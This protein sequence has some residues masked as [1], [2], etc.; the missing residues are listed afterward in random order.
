MNLYIKQHIFTWGDQFSI[1]DEAGNE[2]YR[3]GW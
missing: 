3:V 2:K 1:Y